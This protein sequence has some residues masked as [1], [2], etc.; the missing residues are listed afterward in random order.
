M[1]VCVDAFHGL[2]LINLRTD[3][4]RNGHAIYMDRSLVPRDKYSNAH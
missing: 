2:T 1:N 3:Q 4:A